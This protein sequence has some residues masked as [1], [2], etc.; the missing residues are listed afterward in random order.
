MA[1]N[2]R[3]NKKLVNFNSTQIQFRIRDPEL[4]KQLKEFKLVR[5]ET[6]I[7]DYSYRNELIGTKDTGWEE[8]FIVFSTVA[9]AIKEANPGMANVDF[10]DFVFDIPWDNQ[11]SEV[12]NTLTKGQKYIPK[13]QMRVSHHSDISRRYNE[14]SKS[15][16]FT[17]NAPDIN[18]FVAEA[19]TVENLSELTWDDY[20]KVKTVL[21]GFGNG[22][23]ALIVKEVS[24]SEDSRY[25]H[26]ILVNRDD[27]STTSL[28]S[29]TMD[30]NNE[31]GGIPLLSFHF[32]RAGVENKETIVLENSNIRI[33][34]D[35]L[36][37]DN[38]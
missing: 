20:E 25:L 31:L 7:E 10:T 15:F 22:L 4:L 38:R 13:I 14:D 19:I 28:F 11:L 32:T 33:N 34:K 24:D 21:E 17:L 6:T 36:L 23:R 35:P 27:I 3:L 8:N 9:R 1:F 26:L 5:E 30:W 16:V 29:V 2:I 18:D 37:E 12:K